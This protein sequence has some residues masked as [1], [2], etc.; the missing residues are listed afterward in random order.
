MTGFAFKSNEPDYRP[1]S[2][3]VMH[4]IRGVVIELTDAFS[5]L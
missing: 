2:A 5:R 3:Y 1:G 4:L